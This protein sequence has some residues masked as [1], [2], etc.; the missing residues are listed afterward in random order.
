MAENNE[1]HIYLHLDEIEEGTGAVADMGAKSTGNKTGSTSSDPALKITK[2]LK[3]LV[4]FAAVKSTA[5]QIANYKISQVA[6]RTGANEYEQ[7]LGYVYNAVS[8]T[9]GAGAALVLGG[10]TAGPAGLA[11]AAIGVAVSGVQKVVSI[12]QKAENLRLQ[13]SLEN[14]SIGMEKTRAGVSGRRSKDQ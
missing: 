5:D 7:R 12:A 9:V 13:E 6:L 3:S 8:Q 14:I 2:K 11:V 10:V 4:S 1:Y